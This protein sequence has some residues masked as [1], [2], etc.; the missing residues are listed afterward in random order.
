MSSFTYGSRL[1]EKNLIDWFVK[2]EIYDDV[3]GLVGE[4]WK[5][6]PS[7]AVTTAVKSAVHL[8]AN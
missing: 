4:T 3:M 8:S 6:Q 2:I 5:K 7:T 1:I